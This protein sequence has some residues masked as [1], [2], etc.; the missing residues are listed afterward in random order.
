[1]VSQLYPCRGWDFPDVIQIFDLVFTSRT[2]DFVT[3]LRGDKI[4]GTRRPCGHPALS[5]LNAQGETRTP[6]TLRSLAPEASA[7]ANSAT[8]A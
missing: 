3:P 8:W 7:S 5:I 4:G 2:L 1:M 6:M